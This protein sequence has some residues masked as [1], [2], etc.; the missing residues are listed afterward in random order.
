M[1]LFY[2]IR[3]IESETLEK[4]IE[5]AQNGTA[6]FLDYHLQSDIIVPANDNLTEAIA[7]S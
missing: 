6:K 2:S 5:E 1:P 7:I 3:V 4:A